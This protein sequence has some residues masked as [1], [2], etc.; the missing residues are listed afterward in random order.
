MT[1]TVPNLEKHVT[2]GDLEIGDLFIHEDEVYIKIA[3]L[4]STSIGWCAINLKSRDYEDFEDDQT[5]YR[6]VKNIIV[7]L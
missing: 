7:E 3:S 2:F 4:S 1:I 6:T 5:I